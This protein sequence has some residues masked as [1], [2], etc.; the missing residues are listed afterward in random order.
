MESTDSIQMNVDSDIN[1]EDAESFTDVT[2]VEK[3]E[4]GLPKKLIRLPLTRV[5]YIMKLDSENGKASKDSVFLITKATELFLEYL[6]REC[7][8]YAVQSKRKTVQRR[9]INA[10]IDGV[11]QLCFL[12]GALE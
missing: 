3:G 8:K 11:P 5:K 6:G 12:E 9:D 7:V 4:K 2:P 10:V 1:V